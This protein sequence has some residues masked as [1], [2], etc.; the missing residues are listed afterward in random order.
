MDDGSEFSTYTVI[1]NLLSEFGP[2]FRTADVVHLGGD[3]V[4]SL[5]CWN[6]SASVRAFAATK[7]LPTM[8]AVRNYFEVKIQTIAASHSL[9]SMFWEE[10]FDK[11]AF[12][13]IIVPHA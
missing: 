13:F 4:G 7:G 5:A 12:F 11:G 10:V 3:E 8:D 1:N 9:R 6:E 2:L